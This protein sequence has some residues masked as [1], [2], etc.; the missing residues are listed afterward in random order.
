MIGM[1][2]DDHDR[3]LETQD[4]LE[5]TMIGENKMSCSE[6]GACNT[7]LVRTDQSRELDTT[8]HDHGWL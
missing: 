4:L 5:L 8:D 7:G 3:I 6:Q 1:E 2:Q